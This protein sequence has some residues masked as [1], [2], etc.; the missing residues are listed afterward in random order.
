MGF[1]L[2]DF[3]LECAKEYTKQGL[4]Y[5]IHQQCNEMR[6]KAMAIPEEHRDAVLAY[7]NDVEQKRLQGVEMEAAGIGA[8]KEILKMMGVII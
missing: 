8:A 3:F 6:K 5:N 7:I 4:Q 1:D 2:R